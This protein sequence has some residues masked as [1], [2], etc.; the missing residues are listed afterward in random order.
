MSISVFS[1]HDMFSSIYIFYNFLLIGLLRQPKWGHLKD[2]HQAIKLCESALVAGD[3]MVASLGN[4]QQ[5]SISLDFLYDYRMT[6][7]VLTNI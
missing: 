4:K 7:L 1:L 5:V 6:L 2:L 3:P